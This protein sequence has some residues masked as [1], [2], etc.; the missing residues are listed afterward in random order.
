ME[1]NG[2]WQTAATSRLIGY[3]KENKPVYGISSRISFHYRVGAR[4]WRY[5]LLTS[6]IVA[7]RAILLSFRQIA[8]AR[9]RY[10][11]VYVARFR[12]RAKEKETNRL[13]RTIRFHRIRPENGRKFPAARIKKV[14]KRITNSGNNMSQKIILLIR[15]LF[16]LNYTFQIL[17]NRRR[18]FWHYV[19]I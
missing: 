4:V 5:L 13:V 1:H 17:Q 6:F 9:E 2:L 8:C 18:I 3:S 15:Y 7:T 16:K 11:H 14:K 10:V 12:K 19:L